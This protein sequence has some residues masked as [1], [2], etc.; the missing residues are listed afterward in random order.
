MQPILRRRKKFQIETPDIVIKVNPERADL[1]ETR[2]I[3]GRQCLVIAVDD[4]I[5]V[6][7]VNVRTLKRQKK[8]RRRR[9]KPMHKQ[10]RKNKVAK[11]TSYSL[12]EVTG[13]GTKELVTVNLNS[14]AEGKARNLNIYTYNKGK[15]KKIWSTSDQIIAYNQKTENN[16]RLTVFSIK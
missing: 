6:N 1:I 5:E 8:H 10:S 7:G 12:I 13:G 2:V 4:H 14:N 9:T 11:F 15:V 3:D 16:C